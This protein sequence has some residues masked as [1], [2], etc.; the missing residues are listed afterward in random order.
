MD[1]RR[2]ERS[3][4]KTGV[5][6]QQDVSPCFRQEKTRSPFETDFSPCPHNLPITY[7]LLTSSIE[8]GSGALRQAV[9]KG[10]NCEQ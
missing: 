1:E 7:S 3:C 4:K 9:I 10:Q 8:Q 6:E 2:M 5:R